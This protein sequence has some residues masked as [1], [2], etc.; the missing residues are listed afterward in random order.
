MKMKNISNAELKV[1]QVIWKKEET[2][3][4]E[5]IQALKKTNWNDNT[6]RTLINRLIYKK[7]I[8]ISKK[9]GKCYYYVALIQKNIYTLEC[10]KNFVNQFFNGS[11]TECINFL[12]KNNIE[13]L[14][15]EL[16]I[17]K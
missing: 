7:A 8:G 12:I 1:M 5:V 2:T 16:N 15:K 11:F 9:E 17:K 4:N 10:S 6:I 3:S 14:K 13:E